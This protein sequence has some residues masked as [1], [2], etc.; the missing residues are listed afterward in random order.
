MILSVAH[1]LADD[2]TAANVFGEWSNLVVGER[3]SG[4]LDCYLVEA[5]GVVQVIATWADAEAYDRALNEERTHPAFAVFEASGLDPS[6][7][8]FKVAGHLS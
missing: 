3:P 5:D 8:V 2:A 1:A 6:H 7:T 4:L